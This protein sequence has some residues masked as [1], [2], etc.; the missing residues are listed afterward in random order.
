MELTEENVTDTVAAAEQALQQF[1]KK[2]LEKYVDS[3]TLCTILGFAKGHIQ[4]DALGK[5]I[6]ENLSISIKEIDTDAKTVT[7]AVKNKELYDTAYEFARD[8][9]D[10]YT[11]IQLLN[12]LSDDA[13]LDA[14]L[15]DLTAQIAQAPMREE[16]Q[17]VVLTVTQGKRNLVLSFDDAA[18]DAVSGGALSAIQSITG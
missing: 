13:F 18:E 3:K 4:F 2:K 11:N 5:A 1:D 16:E 12:K 17:E 7:V 9:R 15:G 14:S 8:L 6:F 10:R